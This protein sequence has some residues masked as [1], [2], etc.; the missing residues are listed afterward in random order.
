MPRK[1]LALALASVGLVASSYA[2][3]NPNDAYGPPPEGVAPVG[4][5]WD[6]PGA[7]IVD[8]KDSLSDAE[9]DELLAEVT[10][11]FPG[12]SFESTDFDADT[13]IKLARLPASRAASLIAAIGDDPRLEHVEPL[14]W[15]RASFVPNDPKYGEQWHMV[16][17]GAETAWDHATG[18]GVTVAVIDTGIACEDHQGFM[19][20]TDLADT[21]CVGGWNLIWDHEHAND[22]HGHGTH[23]AG[24]IAQSTDNGVGVTGLAFHARLMPVKVLD[25]R[26]WG[27]NL[28]VANGIRWAA[29]HG[30]HVINLSLGGS[31][32]SK[33]L[34]EAVRHARSLGVVVVAAAGNSGGSVGYP[35]GTEG[36]IGVSASDQGDKLASFSSRGPGVDIAAPGVE[37]VQQTICQEGKNQCEQY[38]VW[39][40][41]SMASPHVAAAA[42]LLVG[43]GVTDPADVERRLAESARVVDPSDRGKFLFGAGIL[44]AGAA[45]RAVTWEYGMA[46]LGFLAAFALFVTLWARRS[47]KLAAPRGLAFWISALWTGP[48]LLFFA[49]LF[50]SRSNLVVD[51]LARPIADL[52]LL[53]GASVHRLMLLGTA[54]IPIA[55]LVV[56]WGSRTLRQVAAGAGVG[57]AA[58]LAS[59]LLFREAW[60]PF[61]AVAFVGWCAANLAVSLFIARTC[62]AETK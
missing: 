53:V 21:R 20:G 60:T 47:S 5:A 38:A 29:D 49:P 1:L 35:G 13:R 27:T 50:A 33:I 17:A 10:S 15:V 34:Q 31:Q 30:A 26:G 52:D 2:S 16:R 56:G 37:V 12:I 44:D 61:G 14:S 24:T 9:V 46:R 58:Y 41:T 22:D 25:K 7:I 32:D 51:V 18:R 6:V 11:R 28:D 59:H 19:K 54:A 40:G 3:A 4:S 57:T 55:L 42:A 62:L 23:V 45:A 36:V 48:G 39:K 43:A 8:G